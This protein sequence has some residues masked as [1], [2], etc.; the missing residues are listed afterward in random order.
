MTPKERAQYKDDETFRDALN[1]R[2]E[3]VL[4][5]DGSAYKTAR[6]LLKKIEEDPGKAPELDL[7]GRLNLL[8]LDKSNTFGST[9]RE[10]DKAFKEDV[11]LRQKLREDPAFAAEFKEATQRAGISADCFNTVIKPLLERG[12]LTADGLLYLGGRRA[13][14]QYADGRLSLGGQEGLGKTLIA[15]SPEALK[16]INENEADRNKLVRAFHPEHRKIAENILKQGAASPADQMRMFVLGAGVTA[17]QVKNILGAMSLDQRR[18]LVGE[19]AHKYGLRDLRADLKGKADSSD[20]E[21]FEYLTRTTALA[22]DLRFSMA[23]DKA[24]ASTNWTSGLMKYTHYGGALSEMKTNLGDF[25]STLEKA[26]AKGEQVAAAEVDKREASFREGL[27]NFREAKE[28]FADSVTNSIITVSALA[29]APFTGG[30]S[31]TPLLVAAAAGAVIKTG[32]HMMISGSDFD[33]SADN[34]AQKAFSGAIEGGASMLNAGHIGAVMGKLG[35]IGRAA[36]RE[37]ASLAVGTLGRTLT[38]EGEQF[39][40]NELKGAMGAALLSRAAGVTEKEI[41]AVAEKAVARGFI[42]ASEKE[43]LT[44]ALSQGL[45]KAIASE[46]KSLIR[47]S[48]YEAGHGLANFGTG[49]ASAVAGTAVDQTFKGQFSLS[50]LSQSGIEGGLGGLAMSSFGRMFH[51]AGSHYLD[52]EKLNIQSR[53]K[54]VQYAFK[55]AEY[56]YGVI[57][58]VGSGALGDSVTQAGL[59]G[60]VS[61]GKIGES[62]LKMGVGSGLGGFHGL[63]NKPRHEEPARE[64]ATRGSKAPAYGESVSVKPDRPAI[65]ETAKPAR[66]LPAPVDLNATMK[67]SGRNNL[68]AADKPGGAPKDRGSQRIVKFEGDPKEYHLDRRGIGPKEEKAESYFFGKRPADNRIPAS[69]N[70]VHVFGNSPEELAKLQKVLIPALEQDP[71]LADLVK[72]WKTLDPALAQADSD[73]KPTA[74]STRPGETGQNAKAFTLYTD[75]PEAAAAVAAKIDA[76]LAQHTE[77]TLATPRNTGTIDSITGVTNRVG[78]SRDNF[79]RSVDSTAKQPVV[80]IDPEVSR[81]VHERAGAS[82]LTDTQLRQVERVLGLK[83]NTLLYDSQNNL[84]LR[85]S[86][87]TNSLPVSADHLYVKESQSPVGGKVDRQALYELS[88]RVGL[89]PPEVAA[90]KADARETPP[91]QEQLSPVEGKAE[92]ER[93][94]RPWEQA[95][96]R[97]TF[98][99][100]GKLENLKQDLDIHFWN[101]PSTRRA[102]LIKDLNENI[103]IMV[104]EAPDGGPKIHNGNTR[105][106]YAKL[107]GIPDS[108]ISVFDI[109]S[110][111]KISMEDFRK[112][113]EK[114]HGERQSGAAAEA[115]PQGA[116]RKLDN[117]LQTTQKQLQELTGKDNS[118]ANH[119]AQKLIAP[120]GEQLCMQ[121]F[122]SDKPP[123]AVEQVL[124][125]VRRNGKWDEGKASEVFQQL[126]LERERSLRDSA[127]ALTKVFGF[128]KPLSSRSTAAHGIEQKEPNPWAKKQV[129]DLGGGNSIELA[130]DKKVL[131]GIPDKQGVVAPQGELGYDEAGVYVKDKGSQ[132]GIWVNGRRIRVNEQVYI[133]PGDEVRLG[134]EHNGLPLS[135]KDERLWIPTRDIRQL[136]LEDWHRIKEFVSFNQ[137]KQIS[138]LHAVELVSKFSNSGSDVKGSWA[139]DPIVNEHQMAFEAARRKVQ[140]LDEQARRILV[141]ER[142]ILSDEEF[143]S[144]ST[145]RAKLMSSGN[146]ELISV[147]DELLK[148]KN[149]SRQAEDQLVKLLAPRLAEIQQILDE[150]T[151]RNHLPR[152]IAK[153]KGSIDGISKATYGDAKITMRTIDFL[154]NRRTDEFIGDLYHELVHHE[155][156]YQTMRLTIDDVETRLRLKPELGPQY[157]I[158]KEAPPR[159]LSNIQE[160]YKA[161]TGIDISEDHLKNIL[162]ERNGQRLRTDNGSGT[163]ERARASDLIKAFRRNA[164]MQLDYHEAEDH[165]KASERELARIR[166]KLG[167]EPA[168]DLL[169]RISGSQ[170]GIVP[171]IF[172]DEKIPA[173]LQPYVTKLSSWTPAMEAEAGKILQHHLRQNMSLMNEF[174]GERYRAYVGEFHELEA[175]LIGERAKISARNHGPRG[176]DRAE[177]AARKADVRQT[178]AEGKEFSAHGLRTDP[179]PGEQGKTHTLGKGASETIIGRDLAT[180]SGDAKVLAGEHA[181]VEVPPHNNTEK[182]TV[183]I[184]ENASA[185]IHG[186]AAVTARGENAEVRVKPAPGHDTVRGVDIKLNEHARA[187]VHEGEGKVTGSGYLDVSGSKTKLEVEVPKGET[188]RIVVREG[189]P[190]I[191]VSPHSQGKIEI[192]MDNGQEMP[193]GLRAYKDSPANAGESKVH[194]LERRDLEKPVDHKGP[195][196]AKIFSPAEMEQLGQRIE[197]RLRKQSEAISL[198]QWR[199]MF[200]GRHDFGDGK[201]PRAYTPEERALATE[202]MK[203]SAQNMN[204]RDVDAQMKDLAQYLKDSGFKDEKITVYTTDNISDGNALSHVFSKNTGI[205]VDIRVLSQ[206]E[207]TDLKVK[208]DELKGIMENLNKINERLARMKEAKKKGELFE[209]KSVDGKEIEKLAKNGKSEHSKFIQLEG[210]LAAYLPRNVLVLDDVSKMS[211][212]QRQTLADLSHIREV[213]VS[214]LNGFTRGMNMY[215]LAVTRMTGNADSMNQKLAGIVKNVQAIKEQHKGIS[216]ADAV[217]MDLQS[218]GPAA[219]APHQPAPEKLHGQPVPDA[220]VKRQQA[221]DRAGYTA[222]QKI[223]ALYRHATEPMATKEQMQ[224]YL[225]NIATEYEKAQQAR[226]ERK[227]EPLAGSKEAYQSAALVALDQ[228]AHLNDYGTMVKE[229]KQLERAIGKNLEAAGLGKNDYLL[230]TG[231]EPDGSSYLANSLYAK[232]A[233]LGPERTISMAELKELANKPQL[234]KERLGGKRLVFMDDYRNSGRQQAEQLGNFQRDVLSKITDSN[235][236]P[237]VKEVIMA[238]FAKHE[239]RPGIDPV[240]QYG[241]LQPGTDRP[242]LHGAQ[243]GSKEAAP[244][245]AL[246]VHSLVGEHYQNITDKAVMQRRG[247]TPYHEFLKDMGASSKYQQSSIASGV[248]TPYGMPNNNPRFLLAADSPLVLP[249]RYGEGPAGLFSRAGEKNPLLPSQFSVGKWHGCAPDIEKP[250]QLDKLLKDSNASVVIDLRGADQREQTAVEAE[251]KA[252]AEKGKRG[253]NIPIPTEF[254]ERGS[255]AYNKMLEQIHQ[256]EQAMAK[257]K[258]EGKNVYF[259]CQWGQDRTGMMRALHETL[260][261][262][263]SIDQALNNWK[264]LK[265]GIYDESFLS[266][267]HTD[268]FNKLVEDYKSKFPPGGRSGAEFGETSR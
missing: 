121:L 133:T 244:P 70:K 222:E 180:V 264:A 47:S 186:P 1:A 92:Q 259:H 154:N 168:R 42:K 158:G 195:Q 83:E 240:T 185:D 60:E 63:A 37:A 198:D 19:Y 24:A 235:G 29:A 72:A 105:Y 192:F 183:N 18:A 125:T 241:G 39:I 45:S 22:A 225:A 124:D 130:Q 258:A 148:A 31:L 189:S 55:G 84:A 89:D 3:E 173:E 261:E 238:N 118:P 25:Q 11:S 119:L 257:A 137:L 251:Q 214:N 208:I 53:G 91:K 96:A 216:D 249:Q 49:A 215:D 30:A 167:T 116:F 174:R 115:S 113:L 6:Q 99:L 209:G 7:I 97:P 203:Q 79:L 153:L 106:Y 2:V 162:A 120:G 179:P 35:I 112:S 171:K 98:E 82:Q 71:E 95:L 126:L 51:V 243:P 93:V 34:I 253:I 266:L 191:T 56:A 62:A 268:K 10:I 221:F 239:L 193:A 151:S 194:M 260:S 181:R 246:T 85:L 210:K 248:I 108:E 103:R 122:G 220:A 46:T 134:S 152:V 23:A 40:A 66:S 74:R 175:W 207:M 218:S 184:A 255:P 190:D 150:F 155:Q 146:S 43:L 77:L 166:D 159:L 232:A 196:E 132:E 242:S 13:G 41:L 170:S 169:E 14:Y 87:P 177:V 265:Q 176:L 69:E 104:H 156:M 111:R 199:G 78:I 144:E 213:T 233:G 149:N 224:Q 58:A 231:T 15:M 109:T 123:E 17:E 81:R 131:M 129:V 8:S 143:S 247:L 61:L 164:P 145:A 204:S 223:D 172:A 138:P 161:R 229:I 135:V 211:P 219:L 27:T 127:A 67:V 21:E 245:G 202:V 57:S 107:L 136:T 110:K 206:K 16:S 94:N 142:R 75:S 163:D 141:T 160:L 250:G 44:R 101:L 52:A 252:L 267:F 197:D 201:G 262:G 76:I 59:H 33:M 117:C 182:P 5:K 9:V 68:E 38:A 64:S 256:F 236:E 100:Q 90:R 28:Q 128:D 254:P 188:I 88:R 178:P 226:K 73:V 54:V 263:K 102:K 4:S 228:V 157:V 20:K 12:S 237:I 139:D 86:G 114:K 187:S 147:Y 140:E 227:L 234:A 32:A 36:T 205:K 80:K 50:E 212:Q 217:K 26:S 65:S 165:F 48:I 200:D 230:V